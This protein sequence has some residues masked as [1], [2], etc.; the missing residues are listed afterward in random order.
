M[1]WEK[2]DNKYIL[3]YLFALFSWAVINANVAQDLAATLL[4]QYLLWGLWSC[5]IHRFHSLQ[6]SK[7][8]PN[9]CPGYDTK[10]SYSE[11]QVML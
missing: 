6:R 2:F 9:E 5:R 4:E 3:R 7:T 11:V 10:K 8:P 1:T